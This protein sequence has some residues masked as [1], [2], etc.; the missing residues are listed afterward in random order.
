MT[1]Y[2]LLLVPLVCA[3]AAG[4]AAAGILFGKKAPKPNPAERVSELIGTVK[5]DKDENKRATAA[6]EL[7]HSDPK[8]HPDVVPI[9]ID[10][11]LNDPKPSV[12]SEAAQS[13]GKLRPVSQEAGWALEQAVAKDASMRVRLQARTALLS[14]QWAGYQSQKTADGPTLFPKDAPPAKPAPVLPPTSEPPLAPPA[15]TNSAPR[16]LPQGPELIPP[17]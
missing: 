8:A 17:A 16:P 1:D 14:Y 11:L 6:E 4:P 15:P 10:V 7:R 13:L 5:L 9:L 2:R 3:V 12:R